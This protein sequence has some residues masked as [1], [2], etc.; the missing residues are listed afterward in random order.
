MTKRRKN[1]GD[2]KPSRP[3]QSREEK[4]FADLVEEFD[5]VERLGSDERHGPYRSDPPPSSATDARPEDGRSAEPMQFPKS[6]EPLLARRPHLSPARFERLRAGRIDPGRTLDLH[7]HDRSSA[8]AIL[9]QTLKA[10]S[11]QK[12]ECVLVIHGQGHRS[13]SGRAILRE[14]MS[15][16]LTDPDLRAHVLGFAPAQPRHGGRGALYVLLA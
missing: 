7:G 8:R 10:A 1:Q 12:I 4:S 6:H 15:A 16:W 14:S 2:A 13:E 5:D 9:F 11:A 3:A